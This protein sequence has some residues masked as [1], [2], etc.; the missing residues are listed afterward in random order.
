MYRL[1]VEPFTSPFMQRALIEVLLLSVLAG[2]ISVHVLLRQ[3]AFLGDALTHAVFPGIAVA[4]VFGQSLVV[5]ALVAGVAAAALLTFAAHLPRVDTDS[6]LGVLLGL[7]FSVGV[8]VVSTGQS[9]APDLT[10]LLFG[11]VLTVDNRQI[12]DTAALAMVVLVTLVLAHKELVLRAFDPL[13]AEALGYRGV[14][15][16]VL[17]NVTV[18]LVTVAAVRAVGTVLVVALLVVPAAAARLVVSRLDALFC[19]SIAAAALSGYLGLVASYEASVHQGVRLASGATIVVV[20]AIVFVL[21]GVWARLKR[22]A[23]APP[24]ETLR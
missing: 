10:A 1:L 5:G 20:L 12:I 15:V 2:A 14:L 6:A 11:R 9:F 18:A 24:L 21:A 7:F 13:G 22:P 16:D 19:L 23:P 4:F 3:L 17:L 8:I